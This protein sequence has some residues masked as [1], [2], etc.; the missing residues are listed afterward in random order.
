MN[1]MQSTDGMSSPITRGLQQ[2]HASAQLSPG[3][4]RFEPLISGATAAEMLNLHPVT[5]LRWAR[6]GRVPHHRLGRRVVFRLSELDQWLS[7]GQPTKDGR[8]AA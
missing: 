4:V 1:Q 2:P 8:A 6:E 7:S 5:L 3:L